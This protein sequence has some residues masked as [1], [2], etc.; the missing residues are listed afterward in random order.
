[1]ADL[2]GGTVDAVRCTPRDLAPLEER[3]GCTA[4]SRARGRAARS[5][6]PHEIW[7]T[8]IRDRGGAHVGHGD[9]PPGAFGQ[10]ALSAARTS[11]FPAPADRWLDGNRRHSRPADPRHPWAGRVSCPRLREY[12]PASTLDQS[13]HCILPHAKGRRYHPFAATLP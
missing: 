2:R 5:R 4:R 7:L 3:P 10:G 9:W 6:N 11:E 12:E 13:L 8:S 1:M